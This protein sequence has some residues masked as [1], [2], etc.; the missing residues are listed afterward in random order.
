MPASCFF[1]SRP[2]AG[3]CFESQGRRFVSAA[4][5]MQVVV[6]SVS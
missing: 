4:I 1:L 2:Q 3:E 6:P 5:P